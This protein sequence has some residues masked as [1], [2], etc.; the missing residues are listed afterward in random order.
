MFLVRI[1]LPDRPGA[2]GA[3]ATALGRTAAD[4]VTVDVVERRAD[5]TAVDDFI[6]DL[7]AGHGADELVT[8]SQSVRGVTVVWVSRYAAGGDVMRDLEA[9]EAMTADPANA[10]RVLA[11]LAPGVFMAQWAMLVAG[12]DAAGG[13]PTVLEAT[14]TAPDLPPLSGAVPGPGSGALS[15]PRLERAARIDVPHAWQEA[16]W[17]DVVAGAPVGDADTLLLVGRSGGPDVLDS[18]LARLGH[19]TALAITVAG[20]ASA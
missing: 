17:T 3:V 8:A 20:R 7:P 10:A 4:I 11:R 16:G 6:I 19:L 18:E 13:A 2:L 1:A 9:V 12:P 14:P 15:W 5:G